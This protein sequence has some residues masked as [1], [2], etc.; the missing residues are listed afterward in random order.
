MV[1]TLFGVVQLI[2]LLLRHGSEYAVHL[3][4][5]LSISAEAAN[6]RLVVELYGAGDD[7]R[8]SELLS[9]VTVL[10]HTHAHAHTH[11]HVGEGTS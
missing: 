6:Q 3:G 1:L 8:A 10:P 9:Q 2:V 5:R 11:V 7:V 4:S